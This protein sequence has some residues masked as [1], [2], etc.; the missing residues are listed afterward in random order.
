M[1][2]AAAVDLGPV[3]PRLGAGLRREDE[4]SF[5]RADDGLGP[6]TG[7]LEAGLGPIGVVGC[8]AIAGRIDD[9][10]EGVD[11]LEIHVNRF[12][13]L[14]RLHHAASPQGLAVAVDVELD[15]A[16]ATADLVIDTNPGMKA[17]R[18]STQLDVHPAGCVRAHPAIEFP[19]GNRQRLSLDR[20]VLERIA[21]ACEHSGQ[22]ERRQPDRLRGA[23]GT[24]YPHC[25]CRT[26][27]GI[28]DATH[29]GLPCGR[30][31]GTPLHVI[32]FSRLQ[33]GVCALLALSYP[34]VRRSCQD[35][36][37]SW[38]DGSR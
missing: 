9:Q 24:A 19:P 20:L 13:R 37:C 8:V 26:D 4:R 30:F 21:P 28:Q 38:S 25:E 10:Q 32:I 33:G 12:R 31:P 6:H 5:L 1:A 3:D 36:R 11:S 7:H 17:F 15:A 2:W 16:H 23:G 27:E 34:E 29:D 18:P 35:S 14:A 22:V